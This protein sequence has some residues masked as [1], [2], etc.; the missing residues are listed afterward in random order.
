MTMGSTW[1][2]NTTPNGPALAPSGPKTKLAAGLGVF[3]QRVDGDAGGL[4]QLAEVGLQNQEGEAELQAEAPE[5]HAGLDGPLVV[6]ETARQTAK[7]RERVRA[8]PVKRSIRTGLADDF[9]DQFALFGRAASEMRK[10]SST[11]SA[12][13]SRRSS[14]V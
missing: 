14:L 13:S 1:K 8:G 4:E 7:N 11:S 10:A 2:A 5:Q 3:E 9:E 12:A 6:R